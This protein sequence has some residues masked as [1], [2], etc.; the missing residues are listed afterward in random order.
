MG[1]F[2]AS[3]RFYFPSTIKGFEKE[4][5]TF[6]FSRMYP[7]DGEKTDNLACFLPGMFTLRSGF[8]FDKIKNTGRL[9]FSLAVESVFI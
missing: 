1:F 7:V 3:R 6:E 5:H 8:R 9:I 2:G 4:D